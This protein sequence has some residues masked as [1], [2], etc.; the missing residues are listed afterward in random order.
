MNYADMTIEELE[1]LLE[2]KRLAALDEIKDEHPTR[3]QIAK[4]K[5]L[6]AERAEI[7]GVIDTKTAEEAADAEAL[8]VEIGP[9][10]RD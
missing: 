7:Q 8:A 4:A 3:E 6:Q 10:P 2:E 5:E 9:L 1:A